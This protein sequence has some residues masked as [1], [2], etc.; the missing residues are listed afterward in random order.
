[1]VAGLDSSL[2]VA[3]VA[4]HTRHTEQ[5]GL[6][7]NQVVK[8][9]GIHMLLVHN[10]GSGTQVEVAGTRTHHESLYRSQTHRG[11]YR[12]TVQHCRA[13]TATA[14]VGR[15]NL[16]LLGIHA[17]ELAYASADI[18]MAGAVETVATDGV[19]LI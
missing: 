12:L 9:L 3:A 17:Q 5:A 6:L 14:D 8:S 1:M 2:D 10:K 15:N 18:T 11:I 16:L 7:V 13:A 19:F 4:R